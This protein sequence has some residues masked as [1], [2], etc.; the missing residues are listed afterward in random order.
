MG[1]VNMFVRIISL[2]LFLICYA[3]LSQADVLAIPAAETQRE[4]GQEMPVR[5]MSKDEVEKKFGQALKKVAPVGEPP[6]S[7]WVYEGFTVY[8]EH[9]YVIHATPEE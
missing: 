8:F 9:Q 6:I 5:G 7:S 2:V 3:P 1:M 4:A